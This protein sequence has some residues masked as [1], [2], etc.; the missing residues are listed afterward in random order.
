MSNEIIPSPPRQA[1]SLNYMQTLAVAAYKSQMYKK[2][3]V[4]SPEAALMVL[5]FGFDLGLS[6]SMALT[7][8]HFY[9]GKPSMSGNLMWSL[10]QGHPDW[11]D[12]SILDDGPTDTG[13]RIQ[14]VKKGKVKG[15][16]Q[17]TE[18][19][20]K[21]AGLLN[22]TG[23]VYLKYPSAMYFNRAI[24]IGFK[25]YCPHLG[26]GYTIYTPDELGQE[27]NEEGEAVF[28]TSS[29]GIFPP[30][31]ENQP[32]GNPLREEV[33]SLLEEGGLTQDEAADAMQIMAS[34][35]DDPI[36]A[37][38]KLLRTLVEARKDLVSK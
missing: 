17:F 26:K 8:V 27:I 13:C 23:S 12:S 21:K 19:D 5:Q 18:A 14:W 20:A 33:V 37:D 36:E 22:K 32:Q 38:V 3:G 11:E 7:S 30:A 34:D 16:S 24:S 35:L 6:P 2:C 28:P 4:L 29:L 15:I 10:V 9:D 25:R 31:R 1:I